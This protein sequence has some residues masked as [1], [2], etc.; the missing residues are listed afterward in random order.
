MCRQFSFYSNSHLPCI[1]DLS[2]YISGKNSHFIMKYMLQFCEWILLILNFVVNLS[3]DINQKHW[4]ALILQCIF[5]IDPRVNA[6]N[7]LTSSTKLLTTIFAP[8]Q[9]AWDVARGHRPLT[10]INIEKHVLII[11]R[12][13]FSAQICFIYIF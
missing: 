1:I 2:K 9:I 12:T 5:F 6:H 10:H 7:A 4:S 11:A 8:L 3:I 13:R